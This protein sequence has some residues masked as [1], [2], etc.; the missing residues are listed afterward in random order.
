MLS[1][2]NDDRLVVKDPLGNA[3]LTARTIAAGKSATRKKACRMLKIEV[4]NL[5]TV[6]TDH[7]VPS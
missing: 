1:H 5:K 6:H 3:M 4:P 2:R 7:S